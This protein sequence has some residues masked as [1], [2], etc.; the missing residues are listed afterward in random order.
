MPKTLL[1][2]AMAVAFAGTAAAQDGGKIPWK[3]KGEDVQPLLDE[4]KK[5]GKPTMLFFT[6]EG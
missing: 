1:S 6:S 3:G 2:I 4:A 5:T